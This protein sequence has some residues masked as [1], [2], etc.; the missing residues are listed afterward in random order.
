LF[1]AEDA[2]YLQLPGGPDLV[3]RVDLQ[4]VRDALAD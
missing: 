4:L 1:L 3:Q 2:L